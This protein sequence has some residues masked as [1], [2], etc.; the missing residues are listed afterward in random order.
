MG[1]IRLRGLARFAVW[2]IAIAVATAGMP[3][4]VAMEPGMP[5]CDGV[6]DAAVAMVSAPVAPAVPA[7]CCSVS[8]PP[9]PRSPAE[10]K[11]GSTITLVPVVTLARV[12]P[13]DTTLRPPVLNTTSC[14]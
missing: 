14:G 13:A 11:A 9:Q 4:C 12:A 8:A 1:V 2:V 3:P 6:M 10:H 5:E 7:D